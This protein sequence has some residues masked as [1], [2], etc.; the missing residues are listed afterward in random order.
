MID[1]SHSSF[2]QRAMHI[3][4]ANTQ[5][6]WMVL[7]DN[8]LHGTLRIE[9]SNAEEGREIIRDIF[10]TLLD[11]P[12][13]NTLE[14]K[15]SVKFSLASIQLADPKALVER[16]VMIDPSYL[17]VAQRALHIL[18]TDTQGH[19]TVFPDNKLYGIL[20]IEAS[21]TEEGR[22]KIR[23]I[24]RTLLDLTLTN[25]LEIK[26]SF[27]FST[28]TIQ[29]ADSKALAAL[30]V[31]YGRIYEQQQDELFIRAQEQIQLD[32]KAFIIG[33]PKFGLVK[34]ALVIKI[35]LLCAES[36]SR[37]TANA[38]RNFNI[39]CPDAR[40]QIA[41]ICACKS[42]FTTAFV[43][44]NFDIDDE[45]RR[46]T[47]AKL[48]F[49]HDE[50]W[51]IARVIDQFAI[52][53][54][55]KLWKLALLGFEHHPVETGEWFKNFQIADPERRIEAFKLYCRD[56]VKNAVCHVANFGIDNLEQLHQL[57]RYCVQLDPSVA[58]DVVTRF[59]LADPERIEAFKLYCRD[60]VKKAVWNVANFGIDNLEQLDQ[61]ARYCVQLDP[62]VAVDVLAK[63]LLPSLVSIKPLFCEQ[64]AHMGYLSFPERFRRLM[65]FHQ[66]NFPIGS[67]AKE[68]ES[69]TKVI[70]SEGSCTL[71]IEE[72]LLW[73]AESFLLAKLHLQDSQ[74][75]WL[76][77]HQL[78]FSIESLG[79]TNLRLPLTR[80]TISLIT[81][82]GESAMTALLSNVE[83]P[84]NIQ[85]RLLLFLLEREGTGGRLMSSTKN[86]NLLEPASLADLPCEEH[87]NIA[88]V[89]AESQ[90]YS[91]VLSPYFSAIIST[92][93][94]D[95]NIF[96]HEPNAQILITMLWRLYTHP[97]MTALDKFMLLTKIFFE[98]LDISKSLKEQNLQEKYLQRIYITCALIDFNATDELQCDS[99]RTLSDSFKHAFHSMLVMEELPDLTELY[100]QYFASC[101]YPLATA[102]YAARINSLKDN[103]AK[104]CLSDCIS[105]VLK[106]SL[107][108]LRHDLD[109]NPHL[110]QITQRHPGILTKWRQCLP[111][112]TL[113]RTDQPTS[114][115]ATVVAFESEEFFDILS[116]HFGV[117]YDYDR[118]GINSLSD[119]DKGLLG[120]L[121]D[122][123]TRLLGIKDDN[124]RMLAYCF[125]SLLWDGKQAVLFRDQVQPYWLSK[126]YVEALNHMA[127]S[128]AE[129]L[130]LPALYSEQ[131]YNNDLWYEEDLSTLE[132]PSLWNFCT[133][134][135][136]LCAP[137]SYIV[138]SPSYLRKES[139]IPS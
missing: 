67:F 129:M 33:F 61:L 55:N 126:H 16:S 7:P 24:F 36:N 27:K 134:L 17:S 113:P 12:L 121:R 8:K 47:I 74:I 44:Q 125:I 63:F 64:T 90:H 137:G 19:W 46:Y 59:P 136:S 31:F 11:L 39:A 109:S 83:R 72:E 15:Y 38:M 99:L 82:V 135:Q 95:E 118:I 4:K 124:G 40:Y 48:C 56:N 88:T 78:L 117:T 18:K 100:F 114:P 103:D 37:L 122:G 89:E 110:R 75:E 42:S 92:I 62:S 65:Q 29:I 93:E 60:N 25:T 112:A 116:T 70:S 23:D 79:R 49:Q 76:S 106:G 26:Y 104:R 111:Q 105:A 3:L 34:P 131:Y 13:T 14:I 10:R 139:H 20:R 66:T 133:D 97:S 87:H 30:S 22:E 57:A 130:G 6:H 2:V 9:A 35:A 81:A 85:I 52:K 91:S 123:K 32:S 127:L 41:Q 69:M 98:N 1:S 128:K 107:G 53:D 120:I 86:F 68:L 71:R 58:V 84:W 138:F 115:D 5:G 54:Q 51:N 80:M 102:T 50:G 73:L 77:A 94:S 108:D 45:N 28:A 43:F 132:G 96:C 119:E 101:F 21:S